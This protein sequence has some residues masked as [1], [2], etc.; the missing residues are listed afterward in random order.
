[1]SVSVYNQQLGQWQQ[2]W[3]DNNGSYLDLVG[4]YRDE[5]MVLVT[6]QVLQGVKTRLRMVF[7][8][9]TADR[10]DW[11]WERAVGHGDA[12]ALLW[13]IRYQRRS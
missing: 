13:Q 6:E 1:M 3:V 5:T 9:I 4:E 2:T 11:R 8:S 7:A 10:F 12:W